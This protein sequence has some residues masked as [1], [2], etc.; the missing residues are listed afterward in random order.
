MQSTG[1]DWKDIG[2]TLSTASPQLGSQIPKLSPVYVRQTIQHAYRKAKGGY[3]GSGAPPPPQV[4]MRSMAAPGSVGGFGADL[5]SSTL[6]AAFRP[7][8]ALAVEGAV[9]TSFIIE[10]QS[11]IPSDTDKASQAH[12]VSVA[13]IDLTA[14]LEWIAVPK[15]Q[16]SA[17]L[18]ARV[19]NT[20]AYLLLPGRANIFLDDNFVAKSEISVRSKLG[21]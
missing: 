15:E 20:S 16:P 1:E 14:D 6:A 18:R 8:E 19:K 9:S 11:N 17:F 10:G 2:L 13:V 12:K 7:T 3:G 21:V 5:D 4:M